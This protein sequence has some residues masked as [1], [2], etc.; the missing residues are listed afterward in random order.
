[1][2]EFLIDILNVFTGLFF[3]IGDGVLALLG[4][5]MD[6]LVEH[7][8][9]TRLLVALI[10]GALVGLERERASKPAGLR[11]NIF[12]CTGSALF[13][14]ASILSWNLAVDSGAPA[15]V[16]PGRIA[17]QIVNG[18]GFLGGGV[19]L[20]SGLNV[21]GITTAASIWFVAAVGM[22]VGMGFPVFGLIIALVATVLLFSLGR[23]ERLF[24][25]LPKDTYND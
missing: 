8:A 15:T 22:V 6:L 25:F 9:F 1:M 2:S 24:P 7:D 17:A 3:S 20:K 5:E 13:T 21:V 11:T 10:C 18:V 16:D 14:L 4:R 23:V 12:I 19:I